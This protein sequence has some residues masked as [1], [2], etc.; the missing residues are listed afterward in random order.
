MKKK[1]MG[2][3]SGQEATQFI[4]VRGY[5]PPLVANQLIVVYLQF[6]GG[7]KR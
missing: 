4:N 1:G 7:I 6:K 3:V 2:G 5:Y